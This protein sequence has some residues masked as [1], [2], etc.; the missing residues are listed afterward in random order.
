V[1]LRAAELDQL[2]FDA[3]VFEFSEHVPEQN[4]GL[5]VLTRAT[6]KSD[7]FREEQD[8]VVRRRS[9]RYEGLGEFDP[10]SATDDKPAKWMRK[11]C[12][13]GRGHPAVPVL[14]FAGVLR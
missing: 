3:F 13:V 9:C 12:G 10:L 6:A 1:D 5:A 14:G 2:G 11:S 7:D 8:S 4:G